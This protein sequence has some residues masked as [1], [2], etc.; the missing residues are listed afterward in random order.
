MTELGKAYT[1]MLASD[2]MTPL[3]AMLT[4]L[5]ASLVY[6]SPRQWAVVGV[7]L[8]V[9]YIT[10]GQQVPVLGFHFTAIRIVLLAGLIRVITRREIH[11]LR[12]NNIDRCLIAY[13][14]LSIIIP[15]I[16]EGT[17]QIFIYQL[18]CMYDVVLSYFVFRSLIPTLEDAKTVLSR[19]AFLIVPLAV[20]MMLE[21]V[22][23]KNLFYVFGGVPEAAW[24]RDGHVRSMAVFRCPITAGSFGSTLGILYLAFLY[25]GIHRKA[26]LVGLAASLVITITAGSSGPLLGFAG[27]L[28][29]LAFWALRDRMRA[30]RWAMLLTLLGLH[31]IMKAP[32][33]FLM[34][35]ISD[36]VGGGGY[37]R[38][39]LID[40]FVNSFSQWWLLGVGDT[41]DWMPT[42]TI[43]GGA[44]ITNQF[45]A[46]GINGG[47]GLLIIYVAFIVKCFQQL[48]RE[49]KAVET[50]FVQPDFQTAFLIWGMGA[51]LFAHILNLISVTYF[52]QMQVAWYLLIAM[53]SAPKLVPQH[54]RV[55][56]EL[57][58]EE[59]HDPCLGKIPAI[60]TE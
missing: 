30:V 29:A 10:Q 40:Q 32:V 7:M 2:N 27:G 45:V 33:W 21:Q 56:C 43:F 20:C 49:R 6:F 55:A 39:E 11:Q 42:G 25:C 46:V 23:A 8:A 9:C 15:T 28:V 50:G 34:G 38:A 24:V 1:S 3:G 19:L 58:T 31:L 13:A 48:G 4:L 57:E 14:V 47:L 44:D 54:E 5:L 59:L 35:R 36:V 18:G 16:R 22:T 51:T 41:S 52:D 37:Y 12:L 60:T 53:I 17:S 26:A